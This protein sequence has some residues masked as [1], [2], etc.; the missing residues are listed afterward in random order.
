MSYIGD[1][2]RG[3]TAQRVFTTSSKTGARINLS[4]A[5]EAGDVI[6]LRGSDNTALATPG[7]TVSTA[8][9]SRVGVHRVVVDTTAASYAAGDDYFVV[10][11]PDT[12]TID[13]ELASG[14]LMHFS[15]EN[16]PPNLEVL[17]ALSVGAH[18]LLGIADS[19]VPQ[20]VS[21]TVIRIRAATEFNNANT[22][23]GVVIGVR[24][25]AGGWQYRA[26]SAFNQ[27]TKDATIAA[28]AFV[29]TGQL[30]YVVY[31]SAPVD[32]TQ[33][34]PATIGNGDVAAGALN[35]A[36]FASD[37]VSKFVMGHVRAAMGLDGFEYEKDPDLNRVRLVIPGVGTLFVSAEFDA[38]S[39]GINRLG[40]T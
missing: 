39:P 20:S 3:Q 35:G 32:P 36:A 13:G 5:L 31:A 4:D 8:I 15:I 28:L 30:R 26:V 19:G 18:P 24:G 29:P 21:S 22:N 38:A 17:P 40:G 12:E 23:N 2:L 16:R 7:L 10:Y 9:G 6:V 1:F 14:V 25:D 37:A 27:T 33:K 34:F 11:H